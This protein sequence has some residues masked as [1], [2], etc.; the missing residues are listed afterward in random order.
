[1]R[2]SYLL[3]LS[4]FMGQTSL[5]KDV[6]ICA[7]ATSLFSNATALKSQGFS[8]VLP[9]NYE[10]CLILPAGQEE[11][12]T[13]KYSVDLICY[14][15]KIK[16]G[17][18]IETIRLGAEPILIKYAKPSY[19]NTAEFRVQAS[20]TGAITGKKQ[21]IKNQ[22]VF[23]AFSISA[24]DV[25]KNPDAVQISCSLSK[26]F[27]AGD[28]KIIAVAVIGTVGIVGTWPLHCFFN[29]GDK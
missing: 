4:L 25:K 3:I 16:Q 9:N 22:S 17:T 23:T 28:K 10:Y 19:S 13:N 27:T 26:K 6:D 14:D 5:P 11:G 8:T 7:R 2:H 24:G 12:S 1:M 29:E 21:P 18:T 15:E 20:C